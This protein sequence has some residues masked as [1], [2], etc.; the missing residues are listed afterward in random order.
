MVDC[1][2]SA[3]CDVPA[4]DAAPILRFDYHRSVA[5]TIGVLIALALAE[6]MVLHIVAIAIWGW[7][8][9]M[10]VGAIEAMLVAYIVWLLLSFKRLTVVMTDDR[11]ILHAGGLRSATISLGDIVAVAGEW[12]AER[13][14]LEAINFALLAHP[15]VV[16]ALRRPVAVGRRRRSAIAHRLDDPAAFT[17]AL[18]R[19]IA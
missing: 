18:N 17:A 19:R 4:A 7:P 12:P 3:Q 14:R 13:V 11:L 16:L 2:R 9:A 6:A 10:I 1:T 5:P 15:N 8:V